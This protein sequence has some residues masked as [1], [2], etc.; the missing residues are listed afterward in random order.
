MGP[1]SS[2]TGDLFDHHIWFVKRTNHIFHIHG[3]EW[4]GCLIDRCNAWMHF[5]P[6]HASEI[7]WKMG[8]GG[9]GSIKR[10]PIFS[11]N[12]QIRRFLFSW[13]GGVAWWSIPLHGCLFAISLLTKKHFSE[14]HFSFDREETLRASRKII[15]DISAN[16]KYKRKSATQN[17]AGYYLISMKSQSA[18]QV[19]VRGHKSNNSVKTHHEV[20]KLKEDI[21]KEPPTLRK[22]EHLLE[23]L[24]K[25]WTLVVI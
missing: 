4:W 18:H 6:W 9:E 10:P 2:F 24:V 3:W 21:S 25:L 16:W 12:W 23:S 14:R 17:Y 7:M 8:G 20:D 13:H 19:H 1:C 22:V 11:S 15:Q 5:W